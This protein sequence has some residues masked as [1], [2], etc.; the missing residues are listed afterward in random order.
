MKPGDLVRF[1]NDRKGWAQIHGKTCLII[2]TAPGH[3]HRQ[4]QDRFWRI[5][6]GG[7]TIQVWGGYLE[8]IDETG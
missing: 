7:N 2:A 1:N 4:E 8:V 5:L 3:E 6:V